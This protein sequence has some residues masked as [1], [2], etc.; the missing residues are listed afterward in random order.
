LAQVGT[1]PG[2]SKE[3]SYYVRTSSG[4]DWEVCWN[5]IVVDESTWEPTTHQGI[6]VWGHRPVGQTIVDR[7]EQFR[8]ALL[9]LL[10]REQ[11]VPALSKPVQRGPSLAGPCLGLT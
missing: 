2:L 5:P 7:L 11:T 6:S 10:H 9:S 3:L 8:L 1:P 4:F